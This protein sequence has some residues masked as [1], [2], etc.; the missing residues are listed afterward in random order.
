MADILP[1]CN[2]TLLLH[3]VMVKFKHIWQHGHL[4]AVSRL[5]KQWLI[6]LLV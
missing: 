2:T 3:T 4:G 1:S 6:C 5:Y